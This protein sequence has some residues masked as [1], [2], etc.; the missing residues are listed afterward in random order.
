MTTE[1]AR[2]RTHWSKEPDESPHYSDWMITLSKNKVAISTSLSHVDAEQTVTFAVHRN[3]LGPRS[4]YFTRIFLTSGPTANTDGAFSES[5][6]QHSHINFPPALSNESFDLVVEAFESLLDFCYFDR[7]DMKGPSP[8]PLL[9]LCDYFQMDDN[10]ISCVEDY[11][12]NVSKEMASEEELHLLYE[13][14]IDFRTAGLIVE[15][16]QHLISQRCYEKNELLTDSQLNEIADL[17]LWLDIASI[18]EENRVCT[19]TKLEFQIKEE[20]KGWS[21]D[22]VYFLENNENASAVDLEAFQKLTGETILPY[23]DVNAALVLLK[24]EHKHVST[25]FRKIPAI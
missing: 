7:V 10:F 13:D 12:K 11:S 9:F 24:E 4:E 21:R 1:T 8:V 25:M 3:I 5:R 23:V 17:P 15:R 6:N 18:I 20:S 22:I 14:I 2:N 16:G 19:K